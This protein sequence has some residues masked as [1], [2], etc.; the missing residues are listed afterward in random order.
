MANAVLQPERD[1]SEASRESARAIAAATSQVELALKEAEW[2]VDQLG[3]NVSRL[4]AELDE[5]RA[6]LRLHE[7]RGGDPVVTQDLAR[8]IAAMQ[9][10]VTSAIQQLQFYDRMFQHLSHVRD[11]MA[12]VAVRQGAHAQDE[13]SGTNVATRNQPDWEKMRQRL[14]AR[15]VSEPQRELLDLMLPPSSAARAFERRDRAAAGSIELF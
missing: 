2:P 7:G 10:E 6:A 15:L 4:S 5:L 13:E 9:G 1:V 12:A 3:S 11:Y 8:A 14:H